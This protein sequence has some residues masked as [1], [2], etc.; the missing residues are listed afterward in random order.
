MATNTTR[1]AIR[2]G[3]GCLGLQPCG[4]CRDQRSDQWPSGQD[5]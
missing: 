3:L 5:D 1:V 4:T 2:T